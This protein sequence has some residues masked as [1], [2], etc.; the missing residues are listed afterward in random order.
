MSLYF[1]SCKLHIRLIGAA[2]VNNAWCTIRKIKNIRNISDEKVYGFSQIGHYC[3]IYKDSFGWIICFSLIF[4]RE[5]GII[6]PRQAD[7]IV[8]Q[9]G[10]NGRTI[11][12]S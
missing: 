1:A 11:D 3:G 8:Y 6:K 7:M 4:R 2:S 12:S 5:S 9:E 10:N